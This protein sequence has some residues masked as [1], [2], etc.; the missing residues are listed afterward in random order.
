MR[1]ETPEP[2]PTLLVFTHRSLSDFI[3]WGRSHDFA[4]PDEASV[5]GR[6]VAVLHSSK[7]VY[8]VHRD[9]DVDDKLV[10]V[11]AEAVDTVRAAVPQGLERLFARIDRVA[12]SAAAP[13]LAIPPQWS[14]YQHD[15]L[16]TFFA[17]P[18]SADH[19]AFRWIVEVLSDCSIFFSDLTQRGTAIQLAEF[20]PDPKPVDWAR[21]GLASAQERAKSLLPQRLRADEALQNLIDLEAVG[22]GSVTRGRTYSAWLTSLTDGQ[23]H[24]LSHVSEE[25]L[26]VRGPAGSG[27]TLTLE[28]KAVQELYRSNDQGD[29][30]RILYATHSWALADQVDTSIGQLD[31]RDLAKGSIDVMPLVYLREVIHG[32]LPDGVELL[33]EDSLEGKK[34]QLRLISESIEAIVSSDWPSYEPDVSQDILEGVKQGSGSSERVALSWDLMR[35]FIEVMDPNQIKPGLN[36]LRKYL[37]LDREPWMIELPAKADREFAFGVYRQYVGRLVEEGQLTTDQ[38]LDDFRRYLESYTWNIRREGEG[39]DLIL[40]DE[41]HLSNDTERYILHLLTSDPDSYPRLVVAMDPRQSP[42]ALLTGLADRELDRNFGHGSRPERPSARSVELTSTHR[43]TPE[44]LKFVR[45]LHNSF[46]NLLSLGEDWRVSYISASAANARGEVPEVMLMSNAEGAARFAIEQALSLNSSGLADERVAVVCVGVQDLQAALD[47]L[48]AMA[49]RPAVTVIES[50]EEVDLL[51]Y[52]RKSVAITAAEY[53][54]GLQFSHVVVLSTS[55]LGDAGTS[56]SGSRVAL[57]QLYLAAS[58]A[59]RSLLMVSVRGEKGIPTILQGALD[60]GVARAWT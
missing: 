48:Y 4:T 49:T 17:L 21:E 52:V 43:F 3:E 19:E 20:T 8:V 51:R 60:S 28:L 6:D 50:R 13:P 53:A 57:S 58:R 39:Y 41:Y 31:E 25:P 23:R 7:A 59:E 42:F 12:R 30:W 9:D 54:A 10:L 1:L 2:V 32:P 45:H 16:L 47:H 29:P 27:K 5:L 15:N 14:K 11:A 38:A 35:E 26:K 55:E 18:R 24:V 36:S 34:E 44:V 56:A 46:P 40:V 37:E 33:G 22:A